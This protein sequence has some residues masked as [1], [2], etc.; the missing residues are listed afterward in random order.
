[1]F[2]KKVFSFLFVLASLGGFE[3]HAIVNPLDK[4]AIFDYLVSDSPVS[5]NVYIPRHSTSPQQVASVV[6]NLNKTFKDPM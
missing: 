3:A 5:L 6:R 1:M 4:P 2:S